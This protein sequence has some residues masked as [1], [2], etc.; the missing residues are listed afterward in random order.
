[1][2]E[3]KPSLRKGKKQLAGHFDVKIVA[4]VRR[5][6]AARG[7][8]HQALLAEALNDLFEKNG[9]D[10]IADETLP[11]RGRNRMRRGSRIIPAAWNAALEVDRSD[12]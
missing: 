8:T 10:R 6:A 4:A 7:V 9:L 2:A 5:I 1:M 3:K 11:P 12:Q